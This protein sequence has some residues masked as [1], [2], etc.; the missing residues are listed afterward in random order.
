VAI[1]RGID[2]NSTAN[3]TIQTSS[4]H[5]AQSSLSELEDRFQLIIKPL[6]VVFQFIFFMGWLKAWPYFM[7]GPEGR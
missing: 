5:P 7:G 1:D 4:A 2:R 6:F 3:A